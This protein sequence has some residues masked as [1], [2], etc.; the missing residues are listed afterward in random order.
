MININWNESEPPNISN[1][2]YMMC[3]IN[4]VCFNIQLQH[5]WYNFH[6]VTVKA[7][8]D[9][10]E[11]F[12][13]QIRAAFRDPEPSDYQLIRLF[14][15]RSEVILQSL[16]YSFMVVIINK[17]GCYFLPFSWWQ[18]MSRLWRCIAMSKTYAIQD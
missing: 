10:V 1:T 11:F 14:V 17:T 2:Y 16:V 7:V 12:T 3:L 13:D 5:I 15:A 8:N 9:P 18:S 6:S 4:C